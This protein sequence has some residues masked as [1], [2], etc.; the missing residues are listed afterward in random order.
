MLILTL[1]RPYDIAKPV[2]DK[3]GIILIKAAEITRGM[4]PG[5]FN[6][7]FIE[8]ANALKKMEVND[9]FQA[10]KEQ[11]A[12][13]NWNHPGWKAQQPDTTIWFPLHSEF[14]EK[15]WLNGIEVSNDKEYYPIVHQWANA[16]KTGYFCQF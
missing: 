16:K 14:F 11:G 2:A 4:P 8:D 12:F 6:A 13:F 1:N 10:A 5:H 7:Y 9:V 15:G 3:F